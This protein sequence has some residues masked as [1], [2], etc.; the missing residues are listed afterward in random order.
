MMVLMSKLWNTQFLS[1]YDGDIPCGFIYF[2]VNRKM[3]FIMFLAVDESLRTKGYGSAILKEIKNRYPDK[4]IMVSIEPC[5]DSAP[6]IEIRKRRKAF[7]GWNGYSETDFQI[8]L[9]G[10]VQDVLIANGE[11][12]KN[13]F[14]LFF[15]LYSN[16]TVWPRIWRK[17]IS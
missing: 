5:D 14:L 13:E 6:D 2:A 11:F 17:D 7:Y 16:G 15:I 3:I 10:V 4:K 8:K 1:F 9:S 12:R